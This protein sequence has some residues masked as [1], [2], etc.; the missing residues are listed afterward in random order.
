MGIMHP[1]VLSEVT[2]QSSAIV[3]HKALAMEVKILSHFLESL[4]AIRNSFCTFFFLKQ[5]ILNF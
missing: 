1:A 4:L 2:G 5:F 3:D